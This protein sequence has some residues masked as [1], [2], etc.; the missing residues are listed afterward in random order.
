MIYLLFIT[1]ISIFISINSII[2]WPVSA[3]LLATLLTNSNEFSFGKNKR[4]VFYFFGF[5]LILSLI[6]L[7]KII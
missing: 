2:F 1:I 3:F 5:I 7:T 6:T 4:A